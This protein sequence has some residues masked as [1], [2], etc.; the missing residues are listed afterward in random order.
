MI[1]L[2]GISNCDT[3]RKSGKWLDSQGVEWSVH[4]YRKHG[5]DHALAADLLAVFGSQR[6]LNKRGTTWRQLDAGQQA[7]VADPAAAVALM[8]SHPALIKRPVVRS[9]THGWALGY[10]ELTTLLG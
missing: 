3:M 9:D 10:D 5:I 7:S 6:L 4:D 1:T 2:Y 8:Q